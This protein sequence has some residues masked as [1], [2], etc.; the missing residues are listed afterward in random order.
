M[1]IY[2]NLKSQHA[3]EGMQPIPGKKDF[4][5]DAIP[6]LSNQFFFCFKITPDKTAFSS[7]SLL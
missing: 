5:H 7:V 1:S 4:M 3:S 6:E 2:S